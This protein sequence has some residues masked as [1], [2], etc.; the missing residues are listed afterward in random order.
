MGW[1]SDSCRCPPA[2]LG[3]PISIRALP[4]DSGMNLGSR[5][6]RSS[7][8]TLEIERAAM[9]LLGVLLHWLDQVFKANVSC[10]GYYVSRSSEFLN[11][12]ALSA[13]LVPTGSVEWHMCGSPL[14]LHCWLLEQ[15]ALA[16]TFL[17]AAVN[18]PLWTFQPTS[19]LDRKQ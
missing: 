3:M 18:V 11:G 2:M 13:S 8:H 10:H 1:D 19:S 5:N 17:P 6:R 14:C 9:P 7:K 15:P 4:D 16:L 12:V